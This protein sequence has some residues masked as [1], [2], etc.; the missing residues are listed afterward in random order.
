M[1]WYH[2][3]Y[4]VLCILSYLYTSCTWYDMLARH[5]KK[6]EKYC[7]Y[8][9]PY[10]YI[11]APGDKPMVLL[12]SMLDSVRPT[13]AVPV[14]IAHKSTHYYYRVLPVCI[15][16]V[17]SETLHRYSGRWS[18]ICSFRGGILEALQVM[19]VSTFDTASSCSTSGVLYCC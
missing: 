16:T 12:Y 17:S 10:S 18:K 11:R 2:I 5:T 6:A 15:C 13:T 9:C 3:W 7:S 19:A 4:Q 8:S 1:V 14:L